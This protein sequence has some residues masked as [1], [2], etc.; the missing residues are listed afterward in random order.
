[1]TEQ[2]I[3]DT[4][5]KHLL[6]QGEKSVR[7]S[8]WFVE[9]CAYRGENGLKCAVGCLISDEHYSE[10][11]EGCGAFEVLANGA[12]SGTPYTHNIGELL[13]RLQTVHDSKP[14]D[15]WRDNLRWVAKMFNLSDSVLEEFEN[16]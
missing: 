11:M 15:T 14:V 16:D 8:G 6:T 2:E 13:T 10:K 4:V 9:K 3:F 12:I 5:S 1:M 7:M